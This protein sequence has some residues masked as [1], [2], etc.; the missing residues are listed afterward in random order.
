MT[1]HRIN[2]GDRVEDTVTN[3]R[4]IA[5]ARTEWLYG[6][7]RIAVQPEKLDEKTG[8]PLE[9]QVFDEPQLRVLDAGVRAPVG[10]SEAP[11]PTRAPG[12]PARGEERMRARGT[13]R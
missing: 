5:V 7:V 8:K 13:P 4:G 11:P 9:D 3:F 12:G 1:E 2:L 6:C 10:A